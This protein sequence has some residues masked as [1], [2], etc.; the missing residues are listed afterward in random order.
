[1]CKRL[2]DLLMY[3]RVYLTVEPVLLVFMFAQFLSYPV[4]QGLVRSMVCAGTPNC[5]LNFSSHLQQQQQHALAGL[6]NETPGG[7][8][9]GGGR[10]SLPSEIEQQVQEETSHWILY[11]NLAMGLPSILFSV[12]YGSISDQLGRKLFIFLP[13]L[14]AAINTGILLEVAYLRDQVPIYMCLIGAFA[15]GLYGSYSVLN[16]AAFSY[17][18]DVTAHSGRTRQIGWLESM[19]YLGATLSLLVSG[20]WMRRDPTYTS[21]F[22]C[23][24]L[25]QL[26]VMA[27]TVLALPESMYFVGQRCREED[28]ASPLRSTYNRKY[29]Q[30]HKFSHACGRF[31]SAVRSN[32]CGFFKLLL[33]SWRVALLMCVFFVVEVNFLGVSD[34]VFLYALGRPLCWSMDTVGYFL[35]LKVFCNGLAS[36]FVLPLLVGL[37][38]SDPL[39]V[40]VGLVSGGAALVM[41]GVATET[42]IMFLGECR[43]LM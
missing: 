20:V 27:Y 31:L 5:T 6:H 12:F 15:C 28:A 26:A 40:M 25:C 7:G 1:M 41:M 4:Y 29:S 35:A 19:T 34:V 33:T 8:G 14:G 23:V 3:P 43:G 22:W 36:L 13:A 21:A 30:S 38:L 42:W 16:S 17:A 11:T 37:R 18:A 9:G 10:C 2:R 32:M 24:L 39:I